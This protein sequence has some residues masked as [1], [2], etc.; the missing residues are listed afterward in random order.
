MPY[1]ASIGVLAALAVF[2]G[3]LALLNERIGRRMAQAAMRPLQPPVGPGMASGGA[4][5]ARLTT[6]SHVCQ[7][8]AHGAAL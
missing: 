1:I 7:H 6:L 3:G 8:T 2:V 5:G 4:P